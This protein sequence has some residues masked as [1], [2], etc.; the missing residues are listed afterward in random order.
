MDKVNKGYDYQIKKM[1]EQTTKARKQGGDQMVKSMESLTEM[2]QE[3]DEKR[4][5]MAMEVDHAICSE[6]CQWFSS[7]CLVMTT[8]GEFFRRS[9]ELVQE[10]SYTLSLAAQAP[11]PPPVTTWR[12][13]MTNSLSPRGSPRKS[14]RKKKERELP[15]STSG[16]GSPRWH[17][18]TESAGSYTE[19]DENNG[20]TSSSNEGGSGKEEKLDTPGRK[21]KKNEKKKRNKKKKGQLDEFKMRVEMDKATVLRESMMMRMEGRKKRRA[22]VEKVV[23]LYD[24]QPE[25]E[26]ELSFKVGD[27]IQL[28]QREGGGWWEGQMGDIRGFFPVNYVKEVMEVTSPDQEEESDKAISLSTDG[29]SDGS[30]SESSSSWEA[31]LSFHSAREREKDYPHVEEDRGR[32]QSYPHAMNSSGENEPG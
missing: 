8:E 20:G 32:S 28:I 24:Y 1:A 17:H 14:P 2:V 3:V 15:T 12:S 6:Y 9:H 23:A 30:D 29:D 19:S 27:V 18:M 11:P 10:S 25:E 7:W 22:K 5:Q 31:N 16:L 13:D 26:D 21:K 4:G